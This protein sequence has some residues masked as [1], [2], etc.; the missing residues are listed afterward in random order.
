MPRNYDASSVG[1]PYIR[2]PLIEI[3]Y[4]NPLTANVRILEAEA[5]KLA[6]NSIR[7]LQ[8]LGQHEWTIGPADMGHVLQLV[9]PDTGANI[10]GAT[11]TR[12]QLMLGLLAE[13]RYQQNLK[14]TPPP[15][16]IESTA[17]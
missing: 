2:V 15:A 1:T 10:P 8:Q 6:D 7:E 16:P 13:I 5:I 12:Q 3:R 14:D 9:H 4:P 11:M 17:E